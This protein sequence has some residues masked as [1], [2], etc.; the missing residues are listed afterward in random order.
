MLTIQA[1]AYVPLWLRNLAPP[2]TWFTLP[3]ATP[4]PLA[5][6]ADM[7][8]P[9][10][11][12]TI[13]DVMYCKMGSI[14]A[15]PPP[16]AALSPLQTP[17]DRLSLAASED[18]SKH[19]SALLAQ[20]LEGQAQVMLNAKIH[21]IA[22]TLD[23]VNDDT[24]LI[25]VPGIREDSPKLNIGDRMVLRPLDTLNSAPAPFV[26]EVEV[27]GLDK[28]KGGIYVKS[29]HL[30]NIHKYVPVDAK[31]NRK[32]QIEFKASTD[33]VCDQQDAVSS[34]FSSLTADTC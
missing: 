23:K 18:Y 32:Y 26:V 20:Q 10:V 27:V 28:L 29:K 30:A 13:R 21:E 14:L 11:L 34:L 25:I 17:V 1:S 8:I 9:R 15:S 5:S 2:M 33:I 4:F 24:L 6:Y 16:K 3:L 22:V 19:F 12:P 7:V 31:G